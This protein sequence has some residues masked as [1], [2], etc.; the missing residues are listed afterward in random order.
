METII[1]FCHLYKNVFTK[2]IRIKRSFKI[3]LNLID[4]GSRDICLYV[5]RAKEM[6]IELVV[7]SSGD[8]MPWMPYCGR[9]SDCEEAVM[10]A[11]VVDVIDGDLARGLLG[12]PRQQ[13]QHVAA[14][15]P[16]ALALLVAVLVLERV[17]RHRR[18]RLLT[19]ISCF[20]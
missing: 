1:I 5:F 2:L 11:V 13:E 4:T 16:R 12:Q 20:R 17:A 6:L 14:L 10:V 19:T 8:G 9:G 18:L 7:S 3:Q 15:R